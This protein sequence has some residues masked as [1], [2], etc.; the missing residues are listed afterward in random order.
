MGEGHE[1][2]LL[3]RLTYS[4]QKRCYNGYFMLHGSYRVIWNFLWVYAG[5][6]LVTG[7]L[8]VCW[9]GA[10]QM[11]W[12]IARWL[13]YT[14]SS[15]KHWGK[16]AAQSESARGNQYG[17]LRPWECGNHDARYRTRHILWLRHQD[18]YE[19]VSL[20][21]TPV[22]DGS[23]LRQAKQQ[24]CR[25]RKRGIYLGWQEKICIHVNHTAA[26]YCAGPPKWP[27][28]SARM[29]KDAP[30][31]GWWEC[32]TAAASASSIDHSTK[33]SEYRRYRCFRPPWCVLLLQKTLP[34]TV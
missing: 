18:D 23:P 14:N 21:S 31:S 11:H 32:R 27:A 25:V 22:C 3:C 26:L 4:V 16:Y 17:S 7:Y 5:I 10:V 6:D 13:L 2:F 24:L 12:W 34:I 19:T 28:P 8:A 20:W 33:N 29:V 30:F 15:E 9:S 1:I